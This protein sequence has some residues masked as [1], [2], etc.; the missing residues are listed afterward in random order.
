MELFN[1]LGKFM[2]NAR[3]LKGITNKT[4][5]TV[6]SINNPSDDYY[7][8]A[9]KPA[10]GFTW[11]A[12]E[13]VMLSLPG[14]KEV[15]REFRMLS[16]ASIQQ[17]GIMLFGTRTGKEASSFK[18]VLLSLKPGASVMIRGAFGWFRIRDDYSPIILFAGGVGITPIRALVKE[19]ASR[20]T[21]PIH[22][23][24]SS[25]DSY[26]FLEE[27]QNVVDSNPSMSMHKVSTREQTQE[28]LK[29][30][31]N[32]YG[33]EAYY[34]MSASPGVIKSVANILRSMG[35]SGNRMI[36]DTMRGY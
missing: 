21:R 24:F 9:L 15:K 26:L 28:Q 19:L 7:V 30:L 18:E 5:A 8:I 36:D 4:D 34:Y 33:N 27:I 12:G 11:N 35:I 20:N 16:I 25:S 10:D 1:T 29:N 23:V 32:Q 31:A 17:E 6:I 3:Y 14:H 13:H 2:N 22:I